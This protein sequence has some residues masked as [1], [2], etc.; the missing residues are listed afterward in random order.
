MASVY[1]LRS[2]RN[3]RYST[4]YALDVHNRLTE[5]NE[6]RVKATRYLR[7]WV[8]VYVET[9]SDATAARK[10]EYQLKSMKSRVYLEQLISEQG[11]ARTALTDSLPTKA[12][13]PPPP[14]EDSR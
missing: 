2:E 3:G 4:G 14:V 13:A 6:G 5:H 11:L 10:R 1:I 12:T 8:L 7:P 9:C